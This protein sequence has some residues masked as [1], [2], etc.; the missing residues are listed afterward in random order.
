MVLWL[1]ILVLFYQE[2]CKHQL[3]HNI[4]H[5]NAENVSIKKID[6]TVSFSAV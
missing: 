3:S 2:S 5:K 6:I 4:F 1:S